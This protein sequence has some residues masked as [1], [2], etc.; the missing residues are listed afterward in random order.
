ML[1]CGFIEGNI[2]YLFFLQYSKRKNALLII[3]PSV[4]NYRW[5]WSNN[6]SNFFSQLPSLLFW[7]RPLLNQMRSMYVITLCIRQESTWERRCR[8]VP[9]YCVIISSSWIL[10]PVAYCLTRFVV[11][12]FSAHGIHLDCRLLRR[13]KIKLGN[14]A[15][16][17]D[18]LWM[19][20]HS[21]QNI[22][23]FLVFYRYPPAMASPQLT[24]SKT[25]QT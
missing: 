20:P 3:W 16:P 2:S 4:L 9:E 7:P 14:I 22:P 21:L 12:Q 19:L 23:V 11:E 15:D 13:G 17:Q 18:F 1:I 25:Q 5:K 6:L 10:F 8:L 24:V